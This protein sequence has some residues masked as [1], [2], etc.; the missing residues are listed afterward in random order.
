VFLCL[1]LQDQCIILQGDSGGNVSTLGSDSIDRCD[2]KFRM[3]MCS[4]LNY[5]QHTDITS[6]QSFPVDLQTI[7]IFSLQITQFGSN[8][9]KKRTE[10]VGVVQIANPDC[11]CFLQL[12]SKYCNVST[13][14]CPKIFASY[15]LP[16]STLISLFYF[17]S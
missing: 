13:S 6:A 16:N 5:Y 17:M 1:M 7:V 9:R 11:C 10:S 14:T 2:T 4:I 15:V 12:S 8:D 3:N